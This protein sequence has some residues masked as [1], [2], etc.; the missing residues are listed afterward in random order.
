MNLSTG[1]ADMA[2]PLS[3][4]CSTNTDEYSGLASVVVVDDQL[5]FGG[6]AVYAAIA[7][8]LRTNYYQSFASAPLATEL[9]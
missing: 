1:C 5:W 6:D 3:A 8:G 7:I 9:S 2:T 4:D